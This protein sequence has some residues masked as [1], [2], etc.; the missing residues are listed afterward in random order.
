M[1]CYSGTQQI[2]NVVCLVARRL[3]QS[4]NDRPIVGVPEGDAQS[5][6]PAEPSSCNPGRNEILGHPG[7][8]EGDRDVRVVQV[9]RRSVVSY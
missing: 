7:S 8:R 6:H 5:E 2:A 1:A 3:L 4:I 9:G